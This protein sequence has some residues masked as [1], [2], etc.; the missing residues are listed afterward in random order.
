MPDGQSIQLDYALRYAA[1]GLEVFPA[2]PRTKAP[3]AEHG[4]NDATSDPDTI[5]AWWT[6]HPDALIACRIPPQ[7]VVLDIDPRHGGDATWKALEESYATIMAARSHRS[8]RGDGGAHHWFERPDG[9]LSA[10]KLHDWAKR[11]GVGKD[12][13]NGKWTSGIDIL[14]HGH[15]YTILPPSPHPQT[16]KPYTWLD[17]AKPSEMPGFLADLITADPPAPRIDTPPRSA[18]YDGDS[19]ADWYTNRHEW[20]DILPRHGWTVVQ[21]DG[22]HDGSKWRHPNATAA[23]SASVKHGC[24]FVYTPNTHFPETEQG[25]PHGLTKFRAYATLEHRGDLSAAATAARELRDG[26]R[27]QQATTTA[28]TTPMATEEPQE[29]PPATLTPTLPDEFWDTRPILA[30]IRQA[31]HHRRRSASAVLL[32]TLA[33]VAATIPPQFV[34]PAISGS[35]AS[36]NF[37]VGLV[38]RSGGGK[39]TAVDVARDIFP[40]VREDVVAD[41][42]PGSGEGMIELYFEQVPEEQPSG[43]TKNVKRKTKSGALIYLDEGQALSEMG[44]RKGATLMPTLRSAWSGQTIGQSNATAET[45]RVLKAH[46]YRMAIIIGFQ[47]EYVA[48]IIADPAGGTPQRFVFAPTQDPTIPDERPPMPEPIVLDLPPITSDRIDIPFDDEVADEIDQRALA[49]SRGELTVDPLDSHA[50]LVRMKVAALMAIIDGRFHVSAED[51]SLAEQIM[52]MSNRIRSIAVEHARA[53]QQ[54]RERAH[55]AILADRD[56]YIRETAE[57]RALASGAKSIGRKL[58]REGKPMTRGELQSAV[59]SKHRSLAS[60]DDM[61]E[62]A[63]QRGWLKRITD[64]YQAGDSRPS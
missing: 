29:Q 37:I 20:T 48:D 50:D 44:N 56:T 47:L 27:P 23:W 46:T 34:L 10:R 54:R 6:Q 60:F 30:T 19:I 13:G 8:G 41:V 26:P 22:N 38:A 35:Q 24:L 3:L 33:R 16:G 36:L 32:A 62:Y 2:N 7:Y 49:I 63:E 39:S 55:T 28:S 42:P 31:A 61:L 15:R 53:V 51:W 58:H 5:R 18:T 17:K 40:I 25:D 57:Q 43:G 52:T 14:H 12:L 59:A 64:G 4:M 21:G 9:K 11:N 1:I 45:H